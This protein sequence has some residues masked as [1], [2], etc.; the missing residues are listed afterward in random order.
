[1]FQAHGLDSGQLQFKSPKLTTEQTH[2][3]VANTTELLSLSTV[4][5]ERCQGHE[6]PPHRSATVEKH[7]TSFDGNTRP[8]LTFGVSNEW[9]VV[10]Y[11]VFC[12]EIYINF[13]IYSLGQ[14]KDS[15]TFRWMN[16][17]SLS[18]H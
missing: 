14:L 7:I 10:K 18:S 8:S 3:Q 5:S 12:D 11:I 17:L 2:K 4:D 16:L 6:A 15:I 13:L 9:L 1:M